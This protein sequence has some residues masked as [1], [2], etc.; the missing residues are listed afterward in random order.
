[1]RPYSG[2]ILR[3]PRASGSSRI[4]RVTAARSPRTPLPLSL[5]TAATRATY[6]GVGELVTVFWMSC[7]PMNGGVLG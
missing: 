2:S 1:M 3:A 6:P 5:N 4:A 7:L